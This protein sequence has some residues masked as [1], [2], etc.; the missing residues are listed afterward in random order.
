M[1]PA[2]ADPQTSLLQRRGNGETARDIASL[3]DQA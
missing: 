2:R 1:I 3:P